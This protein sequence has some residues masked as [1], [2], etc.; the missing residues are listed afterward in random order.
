VSWIGVDLDG[1]L[2][3]YDKW[4][5]VDHIGDPIPPMIQR[6]REWIAGGQC[7]KIFTARMHG[8]G[9]DDLAGGKVDV[10]TPIQKWCKEHIG[11]VLPVTNIKDFGMIERDSLIEQM[12][13]PNHHAEEGK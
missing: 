4:R 11:E 8:H 13:T 1:T 3:T 7:V 12:T 6:V 2:A 10:L 9:T 5:G